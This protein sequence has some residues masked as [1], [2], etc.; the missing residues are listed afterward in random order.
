MALDKIQGTESYFVQFCSD[1]AIKCV[2]VMAGLIL[3]FHFGDISRPLLSA[4]F[5][6]IIFDFITGVHAAHSS[7]EN[8]KSAKI[9]RTAWKFALYFIVVSA[10]YFTELVIGADIFIAKTIMIFLALTELISVFE[11]IS[12]SGYPMP[13]VLINKLRDLIKTK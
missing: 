3:Q 13:T 11:N 5:M 2:G 7:G 9:F 1:T 6:L 10:G 4:I 8:I 12:K